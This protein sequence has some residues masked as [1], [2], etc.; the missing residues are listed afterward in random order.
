[1][2]TISVVVNTR[3]EEENLP[4]AIASVKSLADEIIVV[5]MESTDKTVEIAKK[6]GAKVFNHKPIGYVEPA[7]NFAISKATKDWVLVLDADEEVSEDLAKQIK[8]KADDSEIDYYRIPRKNIILGHYMKHA[9]W[10]PD[11]NIRFFRK[12]YVSWNEVIHTVPMTQGVGGEIEA[13]E[14]LALIHHNYK[15]IDDYLERMVRYSKI[16]SQEL[17]KKNYKFVWSDLITKPVNEFL[18]RYFA[19]RGYKDGI[20]GLALSLLQS[21]SELIVYIRVWE[22]GG[23]TEK[24]IDKK[25][26]QTIFAKNINDINWWIR[27]ELSWLNFPKFW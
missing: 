18:S 23:Y 24:E 25:E 22:K 6:L 14:E 2:A 13:K 21:F 12:G 7:R 1:M 3:N 19:G 26:I 5:D 11:Y 8:E 20:H 4:K 16:Q 17:I 15:D 27:K 10:W 9:N